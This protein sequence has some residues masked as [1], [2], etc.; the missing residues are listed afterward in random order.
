MNPDLVNNCL[1]FTGLAFVALGHAGLVPQPWSQIIGEIGSALLLLT[2][3]KPGDI[4][5]NEL[6]K[7]IRDTLR[8]PKEPS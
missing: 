1:R 2:K 4:P 3:T 6:P 5:I 8:P 7:E